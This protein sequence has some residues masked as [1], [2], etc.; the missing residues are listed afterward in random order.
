[1]GLLTFVLVLGPL[2]ASLRSKPQVKRELTIFLCPWRGLF[3][4]TGS[5]SPSQVQAERLLS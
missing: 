4:C 5:Q 2:A 3:L 1:M